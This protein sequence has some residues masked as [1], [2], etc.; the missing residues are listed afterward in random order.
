MTNL[1]IKKVLLN[2]SKKFFNF[3]LLPDGFSK[4]DISQAIKVVKSKQLTMS[5]M[6]KKF[7][8]YF[9]KKIGAKYALMVNS[10]SSANLLSLFC[11]TNPLKNNY[12]KRGD[13]C[14]VPALCWSTSLWPVIQSGLK[15]VL[16]D[17]N[18]E[19]FCIDL[20]TIKRNINKKTKAI[21]IVNVLGNC[22]EI[23]KIKKFANKKKIFLIEDNCESLG[24]IY[25][26]K[27]LG[28][29]GDFSS[30][31]FYFS[32]QVT[33]GEGGM[34]VCKSK[35]DYNILK[36]LRA[37]GWDRDFNKKNIKN[38]NFINQGFNLRP[39][40]ISAAIGLNQFK[41][42]NK[43]KKIRAI[44]NI[45]I[46]KIMKNSKQWEDQFKFFNVS[47]NL[48]PSWFGLPLIINLK[49]F[50]NKKKYFEYLS[51]NK[52]E[53]RPIISGNFANQ[54]AVKLF[55]I[56]YDKKNLKN[57]QYIEDNG[58]FIGLPTI[59]LNMNKIKILT[60]FLLNINKFK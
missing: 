38:F 47:K 41:R 28:T 45:N 18:R 19:N 37:H 57:A 43:M 2:K 50:K 30:F 35:K 7:E 24:S 55:N 49:N 23:D 16:I 32:H 22:S 31:S 1:S 5:K 14:L 11:V 60:N 44:N 20:E 13:E 56:K 58:F 29:Y 4:Q 40:E 12:L 8:N 6:T 3:P 9:A 48:D 59:K 27:Y 21:V 15:P 33:S 46:I 34:I 51:K 36:A 42:L 26:K 54:P 10:G 53:V 39:L 17:V 25:K 52:I